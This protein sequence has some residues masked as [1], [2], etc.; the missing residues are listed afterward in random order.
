MPSAPKI[1]VKCSEPQPGQLDVSSFDGAARLS[2]PDYEVTKGK[3]A[4]VARIADNLLNKYAGE[5]VKVTGPCIRCL[6]NIPHDDVDDVTIVLHAHRLDIR[7]Q[8]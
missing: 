7:K 2:G 3:C 4:D 1:E 8:S 6:Q 5:D